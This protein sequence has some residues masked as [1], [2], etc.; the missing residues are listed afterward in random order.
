[1]HDDVYAR[2]PDAVGDVSWI[3]RSDGLTVR[4]VR[5]L[6]PKK[7]GAGTD[8]TGDR[9]PRSQRPAGGSLLRCAMDFA[10]EGRCIEGTRTDLAGVGQCF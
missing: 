1:M 5:T 4:L 9:R 7:N 3:D 2:E 6:N 8:A 10:A